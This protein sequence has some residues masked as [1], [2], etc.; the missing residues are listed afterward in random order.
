MMMMQAIELHTELVNKYCNELYY[1]LA[2]ESLKDNYNNI[3][4]SDIIMFIIDKIVNETKESINKGLLLNVKDGE[5]KD[6]QR[7]RIEGIA[8]SAD[9]YFCQIIT[10]APIN[11]LFIGLAAV[12]GIL[13]SPEDKKNKYISI[14]NSCIKAYTDSLFEN[15]Y[16]YM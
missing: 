3:N 8:K 10:T 7:Q 6:Y 9:N 5:L 4:L 12:S 13:S 11:P 2:I 14:L 1:K 16:M 15:N